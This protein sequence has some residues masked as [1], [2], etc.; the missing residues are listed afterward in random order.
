MGRGYLVRGGDAFGGEGSALTFE[1]GVPLGIG[2]GWIALRG[3]GLSFRWKGWFPLDPGGGWV[4]LAG[5]W[6]AA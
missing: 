3:C 2:V 6:L 5:V 1:G 4:F